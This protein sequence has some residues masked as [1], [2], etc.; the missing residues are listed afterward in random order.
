[1]QSKQSDCVKR[2]QLCIFMFFNFFLISQKR[3]SKDVLD[4]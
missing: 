4:K 1:M 3:E 2:K